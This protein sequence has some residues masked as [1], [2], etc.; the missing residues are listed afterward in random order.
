MATNFRLGTFHYNFFGCL[1]G[2]ITWGRGYTC[3]LLS[4]G[5]SVRQP[6]EDGA[7]PAHFAAA[8][9]QVCTKTL[10][11]KWGFI[12]TALKPSR[13]RRL[14]RWNGS[15]T[16]EDLHWIKTTLEGPRSM[17]P[18]NRDRFVHACPHFFL[19]P[20]TFNLSLASSPLFCSWTLFFYLVF[21]LTPPTPLLLGIPAQVNTLTALI[22]RGVPT[23]QEDY[24]GLKPLDLAKDNQHNECVQLL[25]K[26][27]SP[28]LLVSVL[29]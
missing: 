13:P 29:Q 15:W 20:P 26:T 19:L 7:T 5:V 1:L 11:H 8:S 17:T 9:G 22:Q 2:L 3:C 25:F 21:P 6:A 10:T 27:I 18:R 14:R 4:L 23:H 16:T 24:E 12:C 28:S